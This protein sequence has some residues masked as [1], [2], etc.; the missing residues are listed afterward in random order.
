M[1]EERLAQVV[2]CRLYRVRLFLVLR[3]P[4]DTVQDPVFVAAACPPQDGTT[5]QRPLLIHRRDPIFR[6][7]LRRVR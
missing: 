7:L 3:E 1:L 2:R 5:A 4:A 6:A